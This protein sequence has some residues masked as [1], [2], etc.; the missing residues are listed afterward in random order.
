MIPNEGLRGSFAFN[1]RPQ[2]PIPGLQAGDGISI[3]DNRISVSGVQDIAAGANITIDRTNPHVPVI[4]SSGGGGGG[5]TFEGF[6][7]HLPNDIAFAINSSG[8]KLTS[9]AH[10][11]SDQFYTSPNLNA[12]V[13][14]AP[15]NGHYLIKFGGSSTSPQSV[16]VAVNDVPIQANYD[17]IAGTI[18]V[19]FYLSAGDEVSIVVATDAS[20]T[21]GHL[22][23][24]TAFSTNFPIST[25]WSITLMEGTQGAQGPPGAGTVDSVV[26]GTGIAVD[27]TDP[28]NPV[29]S[30]TG[31][32]TWVIPYSSKGACDLYTT[33]PAGD[34]QYLTLVGFG[35]NSEP[36]ILPFTTPGSGTFTL[37]D[38]NP[39]TASD[40]TNCT[41]LV[42]E[43]CTITTI[44]GY[45]RSACLPDPVSFTGDGNMHA[46]LY[47]STTPDNSFTAIPG[48]RLTSATYT[49][50]LS[51]GQG[52][53][54]QL[55]GLSIAVP[56]MSRIALGVCGTGFANNIGESPQCF[57]TGGVTF[58]S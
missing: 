11:F 45:F 34:S 41:F 3:V 42:P 36:G 16:A 30:A 32:N 39:T 17:E 15:Q 54:D 23:D 47:I 25:Y 52:S 6:M 58:S 49:S 55:T 35:S 51:S 33:Y 50:T 43:D 14:T 21:F 40:F 1:W 46:D 20:M 38:S 7:V 19:V 8:Q 22:Q 2:Q 44:A 37:A 29:V 57:F 5:T 48:T 27:N 18:E 53:T 9:W 31:T 28:A 26:A 24:S 10:D 12:G 56:A 4:S 13:Y